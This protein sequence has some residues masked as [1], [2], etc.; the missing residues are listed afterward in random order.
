MSATANN[1]QGVRLRIRKAVEAAQR[2]EG[3]VKLIAVTK[4]FSASAVLAAIEAGQFAF[5]ENY[6]Q[7]AIEKIAAVNEGLGASAASL[8]A[9]ALPR[10][11]EWHF[12]GPIQS[13]K[14]RAIAMHFDWV[15]SVDRAKIAERLSAQR[16]PAREPLNLLLE[17]NLDGEATKSGVSP[18]ALPALARTVIGL[19]RLQL[20]GLMMVPEASADPAVQRAAFARLRVLGQ[21]MR[22][23]GLPC[24]QLSMGMSADLESAIAEGAT[25][26]RVGTAIFGTRAPGLLAGKTAA[27]RM[28]QEQP[29]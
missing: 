3:A 13:N 27:P 5:G 7:E 17:V 26:V 1:L 11:L 18:D 25:M 15:H 20:R 9:G 4:T 24:D 28:D 12:I 21:Q 10:R 8:Q 19:P 22:A 6:V 16:D 2:E 29:T 14:T 23:A